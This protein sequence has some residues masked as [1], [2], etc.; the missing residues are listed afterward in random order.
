MPR[1]NKSKPT[2]KELTSRTK[3][4]EEVNRKKKNLVFRPKTLYAFHFACF[5]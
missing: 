4:N 1:D 3:K 2:K 5:Y